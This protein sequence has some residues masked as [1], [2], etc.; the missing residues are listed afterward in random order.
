M[1]KKSRRVRN[2][3]GEVSTSN[4]AAAPPKEEDCHSKPIP[5]QRFLFPEDWD[6]NVAAS[7]PFVRPEYQYIC[8][9]AEKYIDKNDGISEVSRKNKSQKIE[10]YSDCPMCFKPSTQQCSVCK[11][12]NYCSR[13]CQLAHWSASHKKACQPNPKQQKFKLNLEVFRGMP[14]DCFE[15]HEFLVVKPSEKL[16][17]LQ[18]ICDQVLEP[19]DDLLD[20][21]GFGS[22]QLDD[23]W[24]MENSSH[25]I[26]QKMVHKFGF[27]SGR[28]GHELLYGYR[29]AEARFLY[30]LLCDDS[31]QSELTMAS[32]YYGEALF[33]PLSPGKFVRGNIVI[34]KVIVTN[35]QR[36]QQRQGNV[37]FLEFTDDAD[38]KFEF[39]LVPMNKAELA[40]MLSV[41]K[42]AMENGAYTTRMWRYHVR[43]KERQ[44][45]MD[46]KA[47]ANPNH[48]NFSY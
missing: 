20:I 3:V 23:V 42:K 6:I 18:A 16:G 40:L 5:R 28:I 17:S 24:L 14:E 43:A 36:K 12:V 48:L 9:D 7:H 22:D 26:Y 39:V 45:E 11:C 2:G 30:F 25:P 35:K 34:Y 32:S 31:F 4:N 10:N 38:I 1:G 13:E 33:P 15:G 44:V 46:K 19:A 27:T 47:K 8:I 37:P 21:P 41:R 29:L